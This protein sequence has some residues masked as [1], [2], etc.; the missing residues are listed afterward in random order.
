MVK[1]SLPLPQVLLDDMVFSL[2]MKLAFYAAG[3]LLKVRSLW[4]GVFTY[5]EGYI[6][7]FSLELEQCY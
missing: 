1:V 2:G 5:I 3:M 4:S 6:D 7:L